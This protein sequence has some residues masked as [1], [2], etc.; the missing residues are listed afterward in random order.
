MMFWGSSKERFEA[1]VRHL[2]DVLRCAVQAASGLQQPDHSESEDAARL[3]RGIRA[4]EQRVLREKVN[5]IAHAFGF[6]LAK[7]GYAPPA[8]KRWRTREGT[9]CAYG[10]VRLWGEESPF[11]MHCEG[12]PNLG[13]D[14]VDPR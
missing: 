11:I 12:C 8:R 13:T 2:H 5:E 3:A 14:C 4:G 6:Q 10:L 7:C 9:C 1:Q